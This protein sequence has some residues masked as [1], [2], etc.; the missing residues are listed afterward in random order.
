MIWNAST[1]CEC[2]KNDDNIPIWHSD[3]C[4]VEKRRR[5]EPK[6]NKFPEARKNW[7]EMYKLQYDDTPVSKYD[8]RGIVWKFGCDSTQLFQFQVMNARRFRN[9]NEIESNIQGYGEGG[10]PEYAT[11]KIFSKEIQPRNFI[12]FF[13]TQCFHTKSSSYG[14]NTCFADTTFSVIQF[15][16]FLV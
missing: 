6:L 12:Y 7:S 2:N 9:M 3:E 1:A 11:T 13:P 16:T 4:N 8:I 5:E 15:Y 10:W 14:T